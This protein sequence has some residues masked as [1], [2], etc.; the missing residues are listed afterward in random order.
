MA[1]RLSEMVQSGEGHNS[2]NFCLILRLQK[3]K[4][5]SKMNKQMNKQNRCKV[6]GNCFPV[7]ST[8]TN[9]RLKD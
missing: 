1:A 2:L 6:L 9:Q 5:P 4:K 3:K 7:G 8:T